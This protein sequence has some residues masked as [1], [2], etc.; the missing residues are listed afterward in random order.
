MTAAV[1]RRDKQGAAQISYRFLVT[2]LGAGAHPAHT[3]HGS[4]F[5]KTY[6][7]LLWPDELTTSTFC[8]YS[9]MP[10]KPVSPYDN[11]RLREIFAM[12]NLSEEVII[13]YA[14]IPG[15]IIRQSFQSG[16]PESVMHGGVPRGTH[17]HHLM[18]A[19]FRTGSNERTTNADVVATVAEVG[20][21]RTSKNLDPMP[22]AGQMTY[23][24]YFNMPENRLY[25]I[26]LEI[27][28]PGLKRTL[29]TRLDYEHHLD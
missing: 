12:A 22:I 8:N 28:V 19:L 15:E 17:Y 16:E 23:G 26:G 7:A 6:G 18:L 3:Q 20:L 27:Q 4:V 21:S 24:N 5:V 25:R 2:T 14:I 10:C 9:E 13:V 11:G 1:D 29:E